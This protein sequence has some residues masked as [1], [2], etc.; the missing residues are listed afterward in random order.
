MVLIKEEAPEEW[1]PA[2]DQQGPGTF[3][4][5]E[6]EEELW[7]SP[8]GEQLSVKEEADATSFSFTAVLLKSEDDEEKPLF[9]HLHQ[10]EDGDLPSSSADQMT[11]AADGEDCGA[12]TSRNPDLNT[13]ED[14]SSSSETEVSEDGEEDDDDSLRLVNKKSVRMKK[15][16]SCSKVQTRQK[17]FTCDDC[18]KGFTRKGDLNIHM[19]IHRG[20]KPF[21]CDLCEQRFRLNT[22][23][24]RHMRIHTG[25]KPFACEV[26]GQMFSQKTNLNTHKRMHTGEKPFPCEVCGQMF[27]RKTNLNTHMRTHTGEKPYTCQ[28]CGQMFSQK[29]SLNTHLRIHTRNKAAICSVP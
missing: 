15:I 10:V 6:E 26:C 4:I 24:K 5:K 29:A 21:P 16:V 9:L 23:L 22:H 19:R 3:N 27:S 18:G 17:S 25:E 13:Q 2:V 7:S 1:R 20:E 11:A 8:E 14:D 12:E 28:V